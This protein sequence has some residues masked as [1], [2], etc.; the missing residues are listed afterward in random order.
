MERKG[1]KSSWQKK[2]SVVETKRQVFEPSF[3]L[4]APVLKGTPH[5]AAD[6][7][8]SCYPCL[9]LVSHYTLGKKEIES[10]GR[11]REDR[12]LSRESGREVWRPVTQK[13]QVSLQEKAD[14]AKNFEAAGG[15]L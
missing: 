5:T 12:Q 4:A 9:A 1:S 6:D 7:E 11:T 13:S 14:E 2:D 8:I 3:T 15:E 10:S